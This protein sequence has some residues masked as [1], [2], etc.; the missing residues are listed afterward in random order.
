MI[1][2]WLPLPPPQSRKWQTT[3]YLLHLLSLGSDKPLA[4]FSAPS[5]SEVINHWLP[6]PSRPSSTIGRHSVYMYNPPLTMVSRVGTSSPAFC[7]RRW[8]LTVPFSWSWSH[9]CSSFPWR[10]RGSRLIR[11]EDLQVTYNAYSNKEK[12]FWYH[13]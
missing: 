2:Y 13:N 1:N 10:Y 7:S 12:V 5:V 11:S 4:T 6:S 9:L 8:P 3:D